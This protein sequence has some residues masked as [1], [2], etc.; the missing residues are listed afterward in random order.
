MLNEL[1][2][3]DTW[4]KNNNPSLKELE[5]QKAVV[6]KDAP[7][8]SIIVPVY[9]TKIDHLNEM[10]ESVLNQTYKHWEICLADGASDNDEIRKVIENYAKDDNR[11]KYVFLDKNMGISKHTDTAIGLSC[12][13]YLAFLDSDDILSP[14]AMFEV[15]KAII[16]NPDVDLIY[17][18][19]DFFHEEQNKL[20]GP[21]FKPAASPNF[22]TLLNYVIHLVVIKT[23][24]VKKLGM[25]DSNYDR[26]Q[27]YDIAFKVF[28]ISDKIINIPKILYTWRTHTSQT[29]YMD[30]KSTEEKD[31]H[32]MLILQCRKMHLRRMGMEDEYVEWYYGGQ[33]PSNLFVFVSIIIPFYGNT[34]KLK[35]CIESVT[36]N[37]SKYDKEIL[38]VNVNQLPDDDVF[39]TNEWK[40]MPYVRIIDMHRDFDKNNISKA[41]NYGVG[42]AKGNYLL[43]LNSHTCIL[44][45]YTIN[46]MVKYVQ[47]P[48]TAAAGCKI[49][50]INNASH[51]IST[52]GQE[53]IGCNFPMFK[54]YYRKSIPESKNITTGFVDSNHNG[55]YN[56][57]SIT[58][59]FCLIK[60]EIFDEVNGFN[61]D[62]PLSLYMVDFCLRLRKLGYYHIIHGFYALNFNQ[63]GHP[64]HIEAVKNFKQEQE[65]FEKEYK[66]ELSKPDPYLNPN[67]ILF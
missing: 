10:F 40:S 13:S 22:S 65:L 61:E 28:E 57:S 29:N 36:N 8:I 4:R 11:V 15:A 45:P 25:H 59:A 1:V 9:N 6:F 38:V 47:Y 42:Q 49:N 48:K 27:D 67:I 16:E 58:D 19:T 17:S 34:D 33:P 50:Y 37:I 56:V 32:N 24:T 43:I 53:Y 20:S 62:Y 31:I 66:D 52:G 63:R 60:K 44:N 14:D 23:E 2:D 55:V 3:Y 54:F 7:L 64:L 5:E 18:D 39:G 30:D 26:V 35:S 46:E 21:M 51:I 41:I 12:G